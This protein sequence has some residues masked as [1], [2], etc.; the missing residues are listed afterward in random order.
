MHIYSCKWSHINI[1][2]E[3]KKTEIV[4][5]P[6]QESKEGMTR[7]LGNLVK[8]LT[9]GRPLVVIKQH[10]HNERLC[11]QKMSETDERAMK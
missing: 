9:S 5:P 11:I 2:T 10:A 4:D 1:D 6:K 8:S 7:Y 3:R